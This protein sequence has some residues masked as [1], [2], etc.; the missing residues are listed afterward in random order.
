MMR[1]LET[2]S[3]LFTYSSMLSVVSSLLVKSQWFE[4]MPLPDGLWEVTVKE[5]NEDLL[6]TLWD[7]Q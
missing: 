1:E 4:V 6:Q 5:E 3:K 7:S 2:V